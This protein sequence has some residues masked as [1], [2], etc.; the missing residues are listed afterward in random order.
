[1]NKHFFSKY[2]GI[3]SCTLL[4]SCI[5]LLPVS[6]DTSSFPYEFSLGTRQYKGTYSGDTNADI[7]EGSGSFTLDDATVISGKFSAGLPEGT[8]RETASDGSY[9]IYK[10]SDGKPYGK[11]NY[12]SKDGDLLSCDWYYNQQLVSE[13]VA[14]A[15]DPD[16]RELLA[17]PNSYTQQIFKISGTVDTILNDPLNSYLLITDSS[18]NEFIC[19][20]KNTI[21][22]PFSQAWVPNFNEGEAVTL[23]SF[24][25]GSENFDTDELLP[26][27]SGFSD[28]QLTLKQLLDGKEFKVTPTSD[29]PSDSILTSEKLF[30]NTLPH[31]TVFYGTLDSSEE[32]FDNSA[33]LTYDIISRYPYFYS[34]DS[35]SA[36]GT[37]CSLS[38]NY[39]TESVTML[40]QETLSKKYLYTTY[41]YDNNAFFPI[42]GDQISFKGFVKGNK[43][44][45]YF[46]NDQN[47]YLL[48][49]YLRLYTC[50]KQ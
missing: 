24:F 3:L 44:L 36:T 5:S 2:K 11:R 32:V 6:A 25:S 34:T 31:F 33:D 20:Y 46:I 45:D 35:Y 30:Q 21:L 48:L 37:V 22:D 49:P 29:V 19:T 17:D 10:I 15:S 50:A 26:S 14:S 40:V 12:Y 43:K 28:N 39:E 42:I 9:S 41:S 7:P 27:V 16:Y 13:L 8:L 1:M 4:L 23:Y 38:V 18:G 47:G